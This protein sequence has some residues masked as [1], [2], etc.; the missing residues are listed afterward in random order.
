[1]MPAQNTILSEAKLHILTAYVTSLR[2]E[3]KN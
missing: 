3:D 1:M 2:F